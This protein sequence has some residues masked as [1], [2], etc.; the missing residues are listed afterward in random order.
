MGN[1]LSFDTAPVELEFVDTE[2]PPSTA[3]QSYVG[4]IK[5]WKFFS[6]EHDLGE[7]HNVGIQNLWTPFDAGCCYLVLHTFKR[8][9]VDDSSKPQTE[10][11]TLVRYVADAVDKMTPRGVEV[12]FSHS[13]EEYNEPS[14][15]GY[16]M[17]VWYGKEASQA[18]HTSI[19]VK[20]SHLE[21]ALKGPLCK[22]LLHA[23][24]P[25]SIYE[26]SKGIPTS[27]GTY[28]DPRRPSPGPECHLLSQLDPRPCPG[29]F[30][31]SRLSV[32]SCTPTQPTSRP[33]ST[34]HC[35]SLGSLLGI[36]TP[37]NFTFENMVSIPIHQNKK[38]QDEDE[39]GHD[40]D[41]DDPE[42]D[43]VSSSSSSS[44][45][46]LSPT[47]S[48]ARP[49]AGP[50]LAGISGSKGPMIPKLALESLQQV[51]KPTVPSISIQQKQAVSSVEAPRPVV[52]V[53][54]LARTL[55]PHGDSSAGNGPTPASSELP[56]ESVTEVRIKKISYYTKEASKITEHLYVG[57]KEPAG[58]IELLQRIGITDI[59]NMAATICKDN[60]PGQFRYWDYS[61]HDCSDEHIYSVFPDILDKIERIRLSGGK[62]YVHCVQGVSRSCTCIIAYLMW[63]H[64]WKYDQ[65]YDFV[66]ERRPV[67]SPNT[68][69]IAS[70]LT[71]QQ[72]LLNQQQATLYR[73][74]PYDPEFP[75]P[76]VLRDEGSCAFHCN[77]PDKRRG[78]AADPRAEV[79]ALDPRTCYLLVSPKSI[80]IWKGA[81]CPERWVEELHTQY[82]RVTTYCFGDRVGG[83]GGSQPL[84]PETIHQGEEPEQ[85]WTVLDAVSGPRLTAKEIADLDPLYAPVNAVR[86]TQ[87]LEKYYQDILAFP[88]F[89][90]S[91]PEHTREKRK[92]SAGAYESDRPR[93]KSPRDQ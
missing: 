37:S 11:A 12:P 62:A 1:R 41:S 6:A 61:L 13:D 82:P 57:S 53:L 34:L 74:A 50:P 49:F 86:H 10:H 5:V 16:H 22:A 15:Y 78:P 30:T 83:C 66:K 8:Y 75:I 77:G 52:P 17:Y 43:T 35:G 24:H 68:G 81:L 29:G 38:R 76:F 55:A 89:E 18:A 4:N 42:S 85:F 45:G 73:L 46:T 51:G 9:V 27:N 67:C 47:F 25:I 40:S 7:V 90:E 63:K 33:G 32:R 60:F 14:T 80:F 93:S 54:N 79:A 84:S 39:M 28:E 21:R 88:P 92:R 69:F 36:S 91:I 87:A 58:D 70:L 56:N 20:A 26:A 59:F 64:M 71:L 2:L 48:P 3:T 31:C 23:G 44:R 65:T 19:L 72:H